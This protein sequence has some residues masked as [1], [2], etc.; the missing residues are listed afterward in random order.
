MTPRRR[1]VRE[2]R[3]GADRTA[4]PA[5]SATPRR[6]RGASEVEEDMS[7]AERFEAFRRHQ[8]FE[9]SH[10][11]A[12]ADTLGFTPD[13]FQSE[14]MEGVEGG[15]SVLVAAPTGAGKTVVGEFACD[16]AVARGRRAFY[17]TP[18]KALSNQKYADLR[19]RF[20]EANVGLLTGDV[21][22]NAGAP[23]VV[24]TT[25]V[26]R[27]M[28]YAGADLSALSHV[29]LDEVHYLADRFR[30]PVWEEVII[31]LP[32][33][34]R[35]VALSATVSNAEEFG[36][37]MRAVRGSCRIVVSERRPVPL[38]QHMMV[39]GVL[40]DLY[41]PSSRGA[42]RLN[43]ELVAAVERPARDPG[44]RS[45]GSRGRR[46]ASPP[47]GRR[48]SRPQALIALDRAR[49]LPAIVFIFSRAGCDDAV[50]AVVSAGITLTSR[51]EA[52][53]IRA[54]VEEAVAT[55]PVEDHAVLGVSRWADALERGIAAHHAGLLPIMKETVERLFARGLVKVV[56]ATETLAL[57]INMPART[58]VIE[59]LTKWNGA[60]HVQLSAGEYT[61]LSGRAGRRG[62]DSEGH[63]VVLHRGATAPEEVSALASRRTY[64]LVSA[65][66]PTYNMVVNLLTQSSREAT[67]DVLETSFAQFQ[68]DGAVVGL[69]RRAR[70]RRRE[71]TDLEGRVSCERGDAREYFAWRD[72]LAALQ[73]G[74]A[75]ARVEEG[76]RAAAR[77]LRDV[78]PGDVVAWR[79]GRRVDHA[80]ALA[81]SERALDA[82]VVQVVDLSG[83]LRLLAPADGAA[84]LGVVG[85]LP[86][87]ADLRARTGR[88]RSALAER[89]RVLV[90]SGT[91]EDPPDRP[92]RAEDARIEELGRRI[93][94]HPV[95]GCP[96]REQHA[97]AGHA[98]RRARREYEHL[99]RSIEAR[100]NSV[101]QEFDRVCAVLDDL[102][103]L[104]GEEVTEAGQQLRRVFGERDLVTVE[105]IRSGA[106]DGLSG[107]EL[108]AIASTVVFDARSDLDPD[109]DPALPGGP[110]GPLARA[111]AA[112]RAAQDRVSRAE[113]RAGAAPTPAVEPGLM[114][115]VHAWASGAALGT[116]LDEA[117]LQGGDFVRWVRQV[118]DLLDQV[119]HVDRPDL[120]RSA[121]RA[122]DL[123]VRGVVA[124]SAA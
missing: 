31:H 7:A 122:R 1:R 85:R 30:G 59:S 4:S 10:R 35:I 124:W 110:D 48:E 2:R 21:S 19:R 8:S 93:R 95:H 12:F 81:R 3:D 62:I 29:V 92:G 73:K 108:A 96:D 47:R 52:D 100:T 32:A 49:L 34:V 87:D 80:V 71:M 54:V 63:A 55:I 107:P 114:V 94:A 109:L 89:L 121:R 9:S 97:A 66:H 90:R 45:R 88:D 106:W 57:G 22:V 120:A 28:I 15:E 24:M 115:A 75:H 111:W 91:L 17:T 20:G 51:P 79:R 61:Q 37:W 60:A 118:M 13:D 116:A 65:F 123:L 101:A 72:E 38:Y 5:S 36:A 70:E 14:A 77:A 69:A 26:L 42:L 105:A 84:G 64:P 56:Y 25:E 82:L 46:D 67:R 6:P 113:A 117:D 11:R 99:A 103:F 83:R 44:R 23:V 58:V 53:R 50:S 119:R 40:Y 112:T 98:W 39:V 43:P 74:Q 18:I 68:A 33:H 76:R 16:L 102:G 78:R 104:D 86:S 41:A 27:N